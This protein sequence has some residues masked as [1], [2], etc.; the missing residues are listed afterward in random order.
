MKKC[1]NC[2]EEHDENYASGR[3]CSSLC[4]KSFST[5]K[6]RKEI[7]AKISEKM[8][9]PYIERNCEICGIP[10]LTRPNYRKTCCS[11]SC[12]AKKYTSSQEVKDKLS[13]HFREIAKRRYESNDLTIGWQSRKKMK[14]SGP[15]LEAIEI[16]KEFEISNYE[17]EHKVGK[18]FLDFAFLDLTSI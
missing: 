16:F 10:F 7:N 1:E 3:F 12:K 6:N 17:M 2:E 5:K 8:K 4:A 15:E 9:K 18:Y 13:K 14:R 11:L